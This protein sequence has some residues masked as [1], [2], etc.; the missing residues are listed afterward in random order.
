MPEETNTFQI[1]VEISGKTTMLWV[2]SA[3]LVQDL[4]QKLERHL[5]IPSSY[6]RLLY[7]GKKLMNPHL[8]YFYNIFKDASL[9]ATF[10][11][12]GGSIG[13]TSVAPSFSYKDAVRKD[14]A[15]PQSVK[16]AEAPKPFLVDKM[17]DTP[18]IEISHPSLD[19]QYQTFADT[20][21]ICRFNGLWPHT[22]DL[23]QWLHSN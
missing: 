15:Q 1:Q 2:S 5:G 8:L 7:K 19:D 21:I 4:L 13:Q 22:A 20:T 14:A 17:E 11:L 6:L 9:V 10:R 23:Y 12:R 16:P 18:S 3:D